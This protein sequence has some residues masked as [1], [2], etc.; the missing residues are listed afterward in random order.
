MEEEPRTVTPVP[1][2]PVEPQADHRH[3][4]ARAVLDSPEFQ[5]LVSRRWRLSLLLTFALFVVYYGFIL[6][7]AV[8]K[9][10]LATRVGETTTLGILLGMAVILLSWVLTAWY[11]VWANAQYDRECERLRARLRS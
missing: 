6:L 7:V 10:L 1:V 8:N 4:A 5:G 11:V 2:A 9:P 3:A